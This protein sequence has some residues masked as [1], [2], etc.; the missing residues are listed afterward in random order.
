MRYIF[1][2]FFLKEFFQTCRRPLPCGHPCGGI[3]SEN[4][5]APCLV[6]GCQPHPYY[7]DGCCPVCADPWASNAVI[8]VNLDHF[9]KMYLG[10]RLP[11]V[12]QVC[13]GIF[14]LNIKSKL[15]YTCSEILTIQMKVGY[16]HL[17][18]KFEVHLIYFLA[19]LWPHISSHL[20][21][22]NATKS[23]ARIQN[24]VWVY[25]MPTL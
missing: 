3:P 21:Q 17:S 15:P 22:T 4:S 24:Y 20:Y 12:L 1:D 11:Y 14:I 25:D 19:W 9:L 8:Q 18:T 6:E 13:S 7:G 10:N 23:L 5:C 16:I 2:F